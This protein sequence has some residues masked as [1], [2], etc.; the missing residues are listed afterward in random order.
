MMHDDG[1]FGLWLKQRRKALDLTQVEFADQVACSV[2]TV[3]KIESGLRRPSKQIAERF[4]A[5]L[6]IPPEERAA[7]VAFA[8]DLDANQVAPR[9]PSNALTP[10]HHLPAQSTP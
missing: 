5:R 10:S 9:Q 8:R 3:R 2:I 4:A 7:F 6:G 1:S